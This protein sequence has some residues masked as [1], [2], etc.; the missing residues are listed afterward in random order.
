[1][2][3][4]TNDKELYCSTFD[5]YEMLLDIITSDEPLKRLEKKVE[6]YENKLSLFDSST[7]EKLK[8]TYNYISKSNS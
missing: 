2:V 3:D 1:M 7:V 4:N 8:Q 5:V 6:V